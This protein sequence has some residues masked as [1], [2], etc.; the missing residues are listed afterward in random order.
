M[1][2]AAIGD[3]VSRRPTSQI[4]WSHG[5]EFMS[6][7]VQPPH[8]QRGDNS[9]V[10]RFCILNHLS[11]WVHSSAQSASRKLRVIF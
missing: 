6:D 2:A 7:L 8:Q 3:L 1:G 4:R 5:L 9:T 11:S 10:A